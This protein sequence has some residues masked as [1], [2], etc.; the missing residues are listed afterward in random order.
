MLTN[1]ESEVFLY[2]MHSQTAAM[3]DADRI[4]QTRRIG[5]GSFGRPYK[6][7]SPTTYSRYVYPSSPCS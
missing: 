4:T 7:F 2:T 5:V 3:I 1:G 6:S